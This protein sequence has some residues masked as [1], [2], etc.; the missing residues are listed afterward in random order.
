MEALTFQAQSEKAATKLIEEE[1]K[2]IAN[3]HQKAI[4]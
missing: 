1:E 3:E 4:N 2:R